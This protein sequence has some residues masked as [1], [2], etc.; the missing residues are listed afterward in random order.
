MISVVF[1]GFPSQYYFWICATSFRNSFGIL[2][3]SNMLQVDFRLN[4][5]ATTLAFPRV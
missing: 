4:A 1:W 5:S 3:A 2:R